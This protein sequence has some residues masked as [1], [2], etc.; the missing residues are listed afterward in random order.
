MVGTESF[1]LL[2]EWHA[3][4]NQQ[5]SCGFRRRNRRQGRSPRWSQRLA[6]VG[7]IDPDLAERP[8]SDSAGKPPADRPDTDFVDEIALLCHPIT[9]IDESVNVE[10]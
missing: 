9:F 8:K 7:L 1:G 4:L 10:L 2:A 3:T 6:C 5:Q